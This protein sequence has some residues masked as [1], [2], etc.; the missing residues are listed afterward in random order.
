MKKNN[1]ISRRIV[2]VVLSIVLSFS[3]CPLISIAQPDTESTSQTIGTNKEK[4]QNLLSEEVSFKEEVL[5]RDAF[6]KHYIDPKG[7]RYAVVFPEQVHYWKDNSW[8]EIDNSLVLDGVSQNY[9]ST[10][11]NTSTNC[12]YR[13]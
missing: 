9:V 10:K 2:S 1:Q 3:S 12:R 4:A 7:N 11:F 13:Y 5:M 6:S 8:L